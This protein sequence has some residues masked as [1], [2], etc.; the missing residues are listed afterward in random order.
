MLFLVYFYLPTL[1]AFYYSFTDYKL[2]GEEKWI[3]LDN[4]T[5]LLKDETFWI[6]LRNSVMYVV[7]MV[8]TLVVIPLMIAVLANQK[9]KGTNL[10]RLVVFLPV[11]TPMIS[12][13]IGWKFVYHPQG[14]LNAVLQSIGL[15]IDVNWLLNTDTALPAVA[16]LQIWK[17]VGYYMIIY[18]AGIQ[19]V[20]QDLIEAAKLDGANRRR[21]LWHIYIP[22]LRPV[23]TIV[24]ILSTMEAVRVFTSVYVM[25][26]GG[27]TNSTMA[28]PLYVYE[29]AFV[30]LDMGYAST[31]GIVLWIILMIITYF[32]FRLSRGGEI[33]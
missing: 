13:A 19:G 4:Y 1:A 3:G 23:I 30:E 33:E 8:P 32:N 16:I 18:L 12:I 15:N 6:S 9:L 24:L 20:S 14:L 11:I 22:Q 5:K 21:I 17:L 31:I 10:F 26:G 2:L 25:T 28:L 29:K 7:I 27:P